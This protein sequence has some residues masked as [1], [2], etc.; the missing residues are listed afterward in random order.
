MPRQE[1]LRLFSSWVFNC[2]CSTCNLPP[3][4]AQASDARLELAATLTAQSEGEHHAG[5]STQMVETLISLFKQERLDCV[6][7]IAYWHAALA[8]CVAGRRW[9]TIRYATLAIEYSLLGLGGFGDE[10][11]EVM[12]PLAEEPSSQPCWP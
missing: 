2:S 4:L 8:Y 11:F 5:D 12:K 6:I 1:R 3:S 9:E 10:D 7:G